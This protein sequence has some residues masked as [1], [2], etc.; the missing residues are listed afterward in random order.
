MTFSGSTTL[1][2]SGEV[3]TGFK[4]R[5]TRLNTVV[6]HNCGVKGIQVVHYIGHVAE[7]PVEKFR[8][9]EYKLYLTKR[10]K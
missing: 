10:I 9:N 8:N 7:R 5:P 2:V 3:L 1:P 4:V 6:L